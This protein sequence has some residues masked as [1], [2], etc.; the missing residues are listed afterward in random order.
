MSSKKHIIVA[1]AYNKR[2]I[3]IACATNSYTKTHPIQSYFAKKVGHPERE[4]L[5]AEIAC[6]IRCKDKQIH[7]LMIWRYGPNG[8]LLCAKPCPICQEAILAYNPTEV[9]YSDFNTMVKL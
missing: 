7:K 5:H 1:H 3:L 2:G 6:M 4:F 9:W 8:K